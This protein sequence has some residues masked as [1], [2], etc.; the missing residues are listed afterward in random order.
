MISQKKS[1]PNS[2][3]WGIFVPASNSANFQLGMPVPR[4]TS[5]RRS[6]RMARIPRSAGGNFVRLLGHANSYHWCRSIAPKL[7]GLRHPPD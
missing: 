2:D 3:G 6:P 5:M 1:R 7:G 4:A